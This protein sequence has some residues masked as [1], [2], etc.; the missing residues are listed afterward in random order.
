M[1]PKKKNTKVATTVTQ[2]TPSTTSTTSTKEVKR[3]NYIIHVAIQGVENP[4][5]TRTLC[6]PPYISFN[7]L[8]TAIQIAFGWAFHHAYH[9]QVNNI[10]AIWLD[11]KK[12]P[13]PRSNGPLTLLTIGNP[14]FLTWIEDMD[15]GGM[16]ADERTTKLSDVFENEKY[17]N[18]YIEYTYDFGDSWEHSV[19]L[20]GR[21]DEAVSSDFIYCIGG[22]GAPV[23][24]DVG[25]V[26]GWEHLKDVVKRYQRKGKLDAEDKRLI[27]WFKDQRDGGCEVWDWDLEAVN[28]KLSDIRL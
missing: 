21:A 1:P 26:P 20:F 7:Q 6:V 23:A 9:F 2:S 10:P 19:L 18:K 17:H 5:V 14:E 24:E 16:I 8:H 15:D 25:G 22:E 28:K 13:P 4:R 3:N 12:P 11:A 27:N